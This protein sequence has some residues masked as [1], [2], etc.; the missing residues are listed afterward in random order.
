M[1]VAALQLYNFR[2]YE[3]LAFR[4]GEGLHILSGRNAA[5]KTNIL[6]AL[7]LCALGRSHRTAHD[8]ELIR[9]GQNEG[10]AIVS[11]QARSGTR[12]VA[13]ALYTRE[14]KRFSVNGKPLTR[15]GELMG[16]LNAVLF[17][18]EDLNLIKGGP[19]ER[20]RFLDMELSQTRP[21]YYYALQ[22]YRYVL[23][24][25]NALLKES[26]AAVAQMEAWE[27]KLAKLGA[28]LTAQRAELCT[29]LAAEAAKTHA[30]LSGG[31]ALRIAYQPNLPLLAEAE[32]EA[33]MLRQ[34]ANCRE[35]DAL[36]G[37][38]SAGPHRDD[39]VLEIDGRDAR[40]YG[41]QGQQRSAALALRL[42]LI[43]IVE[44]RCG[45][46]P[47]LLLDDV[48][49]ELDAGRQSALLSA[50][51]GCQ[52]FLTCTEVPDWGGMQAALY[53]VADGMIYS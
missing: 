2:N 28:I 30:M 46:K 27:E 18:P 5:G 15:T 45:E 21:A 22:Q 37:A 19:G 20:R 7:F 4:P 43:P 42:A 53:R 31:E 35:R 38:T 29:E 25:R 14:R 50:A 33:R 51:Q 34:L 23:A 49:S 36:R 52:T 3:K 12:R 39:F 6:E 1:R 26:G 8:A 32:M 41:S 44:Q 9:A 40:I 48:L 16:N 17:S 13:C 24:Q 10:S 47:V 11:V